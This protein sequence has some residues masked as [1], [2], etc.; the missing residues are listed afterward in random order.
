MS[1]AAFQ[2][3]AMAL[4]MALGS[5]VAYADVNAIDMASTLLPATFTGE[6]SNIQINLGT[7]LGSSCD[8][9]GIGVA[10][11]GTSPVYSTWDLGS[12]QNTITASES[13]GVWTF[14]A[15]APIMFYFGLGGSL[16]TGQMSLSQMIYST[17]STSLAT[18]YG[19][20]GSMQ[21]TGGAYASNFG[22]GPANVGFKFLFLGSVDLTSLLGTA[23]VGHELSATLMVGQITPSQTPE[24][25]SVWLTGGGLMLLGT[26]LRVRRGNGRQQR[27]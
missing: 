15:S 24:S 5:G 18:E 10:V 9:N 21:A 7:C 20:A 6:G 27:G 23:N 22:P 1:R 8:L 26:I 11:G 17:A 2:A 25:A 12:T 14:N 4:L 19:A 3:G 16:L 13:S